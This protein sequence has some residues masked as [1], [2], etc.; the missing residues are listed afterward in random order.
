MKCTTGLAEVYRFYYQGDICTF[1]IDSQP[2]QYTL[3]INSTYGNGYSYCWSDPGMSFKE[4]LVKR[5]EGYLTGKMVPDQDV[6]DPHKTGQELKKQIL[7]WRR[8]GEMD[9]ARN[10]Q[11]TPVLFVQSLLK[12]VRR[13]PS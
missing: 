13:S 3:C 6:F 2:R 7:K 11:R 5:D 8:A 10:F 1:F 9:L 4:F 12:K